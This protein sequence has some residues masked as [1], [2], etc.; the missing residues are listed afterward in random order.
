M[1]ASPTE[2]SRPACETGKSKDER[3]ADEEGKAATASKPGGFENDPQDP[4]NPN[5]VRERYLKK[6]NP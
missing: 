4:R 2:D 6:I 1:Q 5:E 3:Q